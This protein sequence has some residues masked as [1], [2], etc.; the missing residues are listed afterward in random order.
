MNE[1]TPQ[2]RENVSA[3]YRRLRRMILSG[4]LKGGQPLSQVQL[5]LDFETSRGP[6]RE[7]L[8]MLQQEGLIEAETNQQGRVVS[9]SIDDL[10]QVF[11]LLSLNAALAIQAGA[12]RLTDA[13]MAIIRRA[14]TRIEMAPEAAQ[15][16]RGATR[17]RLAFRRL[18][19][20]MCRHGGRHATQLID[21]LLDR[22]AMFRAL[23]QVV[24][25]PPP[26][27]LENGFQPLLD[28]CERRDAAAAGLF[29][30]EK[31]GDIGGKALAYLDRRY[32]P[33]QLNLYLE[34]VRAALSVAGQAGPTSVTIRVR[35]LPG[36]R[37]E[38]AILPD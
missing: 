11:S 21:D 17:R 24:G 34:A 6:V 14:V 38:C 2:S 37:V 3:V 36:G 9:Y 12:D 15:S 18:I 7:A 4:K 28:A 33:V 29:L 25:T 5:A 23:H 8:R 13:D 27:P 1:R 22:L 32:L 10:E 16:P 31:I 20:T 35:G 26:Y 30:A 19:G